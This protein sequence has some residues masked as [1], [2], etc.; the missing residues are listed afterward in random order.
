ME[1]YLR[2]C[3]DS[4]IIDEESMKKLEVLVIN[5]GSKDSS[6]QIAHEYQDKYPDTFRVIDKENGN[7]GSCINRGLKE[8]TGKYVKVLDADD[9]FESDNLFL[10]LK[11]LNRANVDLVLSKCKKINELGYSI[12]IIGIPSGFPFKKYNIGNIITD[13]RTSLQMH[14]VTYKTELVREIKYHQIEGISYTDQL[15]VTY[16]MSAVKSYM[17]FPRHLYVYLIG[18][19]GQTMD[20]SVMN[21][22]LN[23]EILV[24]NQILDW[25]DEN[26][27]PNI[28]YEYIRHKMVSRIFSLYYNH[29]I[30]G[31][32]KKEEFSMFS[33]SLINRCPEI[34][35]LSE[36]ICGKKFSYNYILN[37]NVGT[38]DKGEKISYNI[39]PNSNCEKMKKGLKCTFDAIIG[40]YMKARLYL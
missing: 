40:L 29:C 21:T 12:G 16:P 38:F 20:I 9:W 31:L 7:Y 34:I 11:Y 35:K 25:I 22:K 33:K 39:I 15:W 37:Y 36:R 3:L 4:L 18:R 32:Y 5:D 17:V 27:K 8:A 6:S 10:F 1:K 2:R 13:K 26:P 28:D 23:D 30:C 14:C 19:E 24:C